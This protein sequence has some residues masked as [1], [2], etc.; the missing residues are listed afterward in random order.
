MLNVSSTLYDF[1]NAME[2]S[3]NFII[4]QAKCL[5]SLCFLMCAIILVELGIITQT[6]GYHE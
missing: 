2:A 4:S 5:F 3:T 1:M 6:T